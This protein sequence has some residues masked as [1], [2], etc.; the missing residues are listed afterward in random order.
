MNS[1]ENIW[2]QFDNNIMDEKQAMD[3]FFKLKETECDKISQMNRL[4]RNISKR[5][6]QKIDEEAGT[7]IDHVYF[8]RET[9]EQP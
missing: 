9:E 2:F 6:Q 5:F 4:I 3:K 1:L 7:Y 8:K